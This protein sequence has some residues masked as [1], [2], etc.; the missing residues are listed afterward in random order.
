MQSYPSWDQTCAP[1][2]GN[3][4]TQPLDHQEVEGP[5]SS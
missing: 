5:H 3:T 4:E 2:S 1:Y